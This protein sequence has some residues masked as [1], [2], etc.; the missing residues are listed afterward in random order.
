MNEEQ[1]CRKRMMDLDRQADRKGI[2][3]FSDFLNLNEQNIYHAA[4]REFCTQ[5]KLFGGYDGAERQMIAFI[6]DALYYEWSYPIGCI[7]ARPRYAK[8]AESLTHRDVL[9]AIMHLGID[10]GRLGDI[11]C[12]EQMY[13]IFCEEA[14]HPFLLENLTRI[15]HTEVELSVMEATELTAVSPVL[16]E[17]QDIIASNRID[18]IIAKAYHMSRAEA[19]GCISAERVFINGRCT[20]N[21]NQSCDSGAIVSVRGRGRFVFETSQNFSKKG[22]LRVSF[23]MYQ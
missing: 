3:T 17:R 10:R 11:L 7:L 22:K 2:V 12:R 21:C 14:M 20:T 9:G 18:C 15:R 6:P 13:Y 16:V 5:T 1:L 23:Q 19:A 8:F 4:S